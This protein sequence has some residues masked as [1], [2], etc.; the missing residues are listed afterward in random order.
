LL[1]EFCFSFQ[2]LDL[3]VLKDFIIYFLRLLLI[4]KRYFNQK[5]HNNSEEIIQPL[6]TI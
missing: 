5:T 1:L 3:T 6:C 4:N 2:K